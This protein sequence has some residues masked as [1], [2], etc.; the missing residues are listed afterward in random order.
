MAEKPHVAEID[1]VCND[2]QCGAA[3]NLRSM[4]PAA[5]RSGHRPYRFLEWVLSPKWVL[6][7]V[8]CYA[9]Q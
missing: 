9:V 7:L 5:S 6:S 2:W 3:S 4:L 8:C 1:D